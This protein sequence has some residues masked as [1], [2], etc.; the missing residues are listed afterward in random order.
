MERKIKATACLLIMGSAVYLAY[1]F[2]MPQYR[3]YA[4]KTKAQDIIRFRVSEVD[5]MRDYLLKAAAEN[6]VPLTRDDIVVDADWEGNY[7]A[8]AAWHETV[9]IFT[10]Y[11]K[12][13]DFRVEVS[14]KGRKR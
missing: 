9:H 7:S 1:I 2:G 6:S 4:F 3:Y 11:S 13:F 10:Y 5:D 12:Q 14:S 8:A